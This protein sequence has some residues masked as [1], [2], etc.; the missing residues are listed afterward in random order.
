ML[1]EPD[2]VETIWLAVLLLFYQHG[3]ISRDIHD[4]ILIFQIFCIDIQDSLASLGA[5]FGSALADI[6]HLRIP[7]QPRG[8]YY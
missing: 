7:A 6:I 2:V 5:G 4:P 8:A 1:K 3:H